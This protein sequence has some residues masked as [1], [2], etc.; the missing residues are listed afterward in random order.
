MKTAV[1]VLIFLSVI[2]SGT[3]LCGFMFLFGT[4]CA[5][6]A[7]SQVLRAQQDPRLLHLVYEWAAYTVVALAVTF[8]LWRTYRREYR[9]S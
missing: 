2:V 9:K 5:G 4:Y 1:Q 8:L 7:F 3:A 6:G